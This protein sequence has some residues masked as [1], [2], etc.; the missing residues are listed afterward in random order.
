MSNVEPDDLYQS[1]PPELSKPPAAEE[2]HDPY[3]ALRVRDYRRYFTGSAFSLLGNQMA[4][5]AVSYELFKRTNSR[6]VLGMIGFVQIVPIILL[7]L[8]AG[9]LVD[10]LNRKRIVLT[11]TALLLVSNLL[12]GISSHYA[13]REGNFGPLAWIN[14]GVQW[15]A[16]FFGEKDSHYTQ[17]HIAIMLLL[18]LVNGVVRAFIRPATESILPSL[19]PEK[20]LSNAV[21]W[22]ASL[23]ETTNM[24]GP[25][26]AGGLI[27]LLVPRFGPAG[28]W[29][30]A[31]IYLFN[32]FCQLVQF[33]NFAG[34]RLEHLPKRREPLTLSS[35][36]AGA[37][38]VYTNKIILGMI[39]LDMFAVLLGGA[40]ALLPVFADDVLHVGAIG[41]GILRAV[42]SVGAISMA[43]FL[44]H[45]PPMQRAGRNLLVAVVGFGIA[46]VVFGLS[47]NFVL[48]LFALFLTG[49]FDNISVVVRHSTV[50]L[51]TPDDMRG[52]VNAVNS[53]F[54][55]TSNQLGEFE[56]G[57]TATIATAYFGVMWGPMASV[58]AGGI[59]T[60]LVVAWVA[61]AWPQVGAVKRLTPE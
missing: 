19:V 42:P 27:G 48:S 18:L 20:Q 4:F 7:T 26:A 46:T 52:R 5:A 13:D 14:H 3:A 32:A 56:S 57:L 40:T 11:M 23:F 29:T 33:V 37:K 1:E 8:P 61:F 54:I 44:A 22:N 28:P 53:L 41:F 50:Q 51:A 6:F 9:H 49:A 15:L 25:A 47:R 16:R 45:R 43:M 38:F 60:I 17:G 21:T 58:I 2:I 36:L 35:L 39:T 24:V 12:M 55:S 34:I 30:Y 10:R 59:G 31:G